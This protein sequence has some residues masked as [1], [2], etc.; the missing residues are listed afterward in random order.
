MYFFQ[1]VSELTTYH[2][3]VYTCLP[4]SALHVI[5]FTVPRTMCHVSRHRSRG[6]VGCGMFL[7]FCHPGCGN[8]C[9]LRRSSVLHALDGRRRDQASWGRHRGGNDKLIEIHG[10]DRHLCRLIDGV[11]KLLRDPTGTSRR[12]ERNT[13]PACTV[14]Q[15]VHYFMSLRLTSLQSLFPFSPFQ[16]HSHHPPCQVLHAFLVR[17]TGLGLAVELP[18][19]SSERILFL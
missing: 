2:S 1:V 12:F 10:V 3:L 4:H 5:K 7:V 16:V 11:S 8:V 15:L 19:L 9:T 6:D 17:Q 13:L 18:Y 14:F